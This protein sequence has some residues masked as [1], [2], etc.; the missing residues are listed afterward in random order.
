MDRMAWIASLIVMTLAI[1]ALGLA[2]ALATS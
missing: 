2:Y 1:V